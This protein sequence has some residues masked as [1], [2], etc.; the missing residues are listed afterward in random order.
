[1]KKLIL[2]FLL[3]SCDDATIIEN[4]DCGTI[5]EKGTSGNCSFLSIRN[6]CT[7][8]EKNICFDKD[9]WDDV[10]INQ[11]YCDTKFNF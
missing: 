1:M 6:E 5:I 4:C 9:I 7:L 3:F 11:R 2:L 10:I 8:N